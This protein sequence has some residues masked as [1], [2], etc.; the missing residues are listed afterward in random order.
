[1][2]DFLNHHRDVAPGPMLAF[3]L[4]TCGAGI[5]AVTTFA[6]LLRLN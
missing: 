2:N 3:V 6:P 4:V 5:W 1:M